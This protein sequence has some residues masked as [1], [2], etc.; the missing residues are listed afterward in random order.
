MMRIPEEKEQNV[1][2]LLGLARRARAITIGMDAT[3][4]ALTKATV[5][6][7]LVTND[8][9]KNSLKR[10]SKNVDTLETDMNL[11]KGSIPLIAF[12]DAEQLGRILNKETVSIIGLIDEGFAR[13]I[14]RLAQQ[15]ED[16]E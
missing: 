10:I 15:D 8:I 11:E 3:L 16:N 6:T 1:F 9:G 2:G 4:A 7:I 5:K 12:S 13:G 14:T